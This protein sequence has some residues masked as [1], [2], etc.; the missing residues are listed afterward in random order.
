MY[1]H[2]MLERDFENADSGVS[3]SPDFMQPGGVTP[4]DCDRELVTTLE[5]VFER[6]VREVFAKQPVAAE[7][8]VRLN[9]GPDMSVPPMER[10][11]V[12]A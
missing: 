8:P 7:K 11:S 5:R 2:S 1:S 10:T 4:L 6:S 9:P 3:N 12:A